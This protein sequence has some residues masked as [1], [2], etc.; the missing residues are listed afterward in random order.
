[1]YLSFSLSD[2]HFVRNSKCATASRFSHCKPYQGSPFRL[3]HAQGRGLHFPLVVLRSC[4]GI[5]PRA[6][7]YELWGKPP[8]G[9]WVIR[10]SWIHTHTRRAARNML[11][12][13]DSVFGDV[14]FSYTRAQ[15]LADGVLVN[16]SRYPAIRTFWSHPVACTDTVWSAIQ[17]GVKADAFADLEGTLH[18]ICWTARCAISQA[19]ASHS[20]MVFFTVTIANQ[21]H[22][23][24]LHCGP[25][26][27]SAPVLTLMFRHED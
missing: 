19:K 11:K 6:L 1:M 20:D 8:I 10:S 7:T 23:L 25:G 24:K 12:S 9:S 16:L 13:N 17:A 15:A 5:S 27:T 3:H 2:A 26:D 21:S 4:L 18:D 22:E 14:I